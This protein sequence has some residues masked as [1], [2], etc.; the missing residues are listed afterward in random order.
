MTSLI[1]AITVGL[2]L[3]NG[4]G[5][6]LFPCAAGTEHVGLPIYRITTRPLH[7]QQIR[8]MLSENT[9]ANSPKAYPHM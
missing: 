7:A 1:F 2:V 6:Q 5:L 8:N 9:I 4:P 3:T